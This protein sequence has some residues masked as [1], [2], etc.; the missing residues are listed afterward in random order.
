MAN[1]EGDDPGLVTP[2][3]YAPASI[4]GLT[5]QTVPS[6]AGCR[7]ANRLVTF[8]PGIYTDAAAMNSLFA[9]PDCENATFWFQPGTYYFDFRNTATA[10][11]PCGG[12]INASW[13]GTLTQDVTHQWCIGGKCAGLRRPARDRRHARTAGIRRPTRPRTR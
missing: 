3:E 4:A 5:V 7:A 2:T 6:D 12:D 9:D 11:Y 1:N 13:I 8:S 10:A